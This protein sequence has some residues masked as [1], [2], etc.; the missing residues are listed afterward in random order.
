MAISIALLLLVGLLVAHIFHKI[1]LPGLLGMLLTGIILGP[2]LLNVLHPKLLDISADLR[3]VAL[4][5]ILLRAG[6]GLR[7]E[8]LAQV[9]WTALLLAVIPVTLEGACIAW[10]ARQLFAITLWESYLFASVVVAVSPAVVVPFMLDLIQQRLGT[11]KGIPTLI[12]TAAAVEDVFVIVL[13]SILLGMQNGTDS[14]SLWQLLKIPES[15]F[16]GII[17]GLLAGLGVHYLFKRFSPPLT[18]MTIIVIAVAILLTWLETLLKTHIALS[19]LLGIMM[20][21]LIL[22]EKAPPVAQAISQQLTKVWIFAEV[23]LYV[24]VG[25]QVNIQVAW[26][27]GIPG[28]L[29]IVLGLG[30]RSL[31]TWF[32]ISGQSFNSQ[33]RVFCVIAFLPKATVQAALGAIPLENGVPS[34]E[35]ILAVA[36]LS[37]IITAPLG[38][39]GLD[40]SGPR[41]LQKEE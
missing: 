16:F 36:V 29:L 24:L 9:G 1:R 22:L 38:A 41:Y 13:F 12:L 2:H 6:L 30:V 31:A 28:L 19:A 3:M 15:M 11:A 20:L 17:V 4:I 25:A 34:G 32:C 33:E 14:A 35:I 21:G 27:A 40:C 37:I 5:I 8:V 26:D 18:K 23:L 10:L 7:K 39:I